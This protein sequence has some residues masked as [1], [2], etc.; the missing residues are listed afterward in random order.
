M[1]DNFKQPHWTDDRGCKGLMMKF[2]I[3]GKFDGKINK[4]QKCSRMT[5]F[6]N[7]DSVCIK[8]KTI[9][10]FS[11][12]NND[13]LKFIATIIMICWMLRKNKFWNIHVL[14]RLGHRRLNGFF[15][16]LN[17][18][19]SLNCYEIEV[20]FVNLSNVFFCGNSRNFHWSDDSY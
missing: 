6:S 14:C 2:I 5:Y 18:K 12:K 7:T 17:P 3:L 10:Y 13:C 8:W 4:I 11:N 1:S 16:P 20:F 19:S 9:K 15:L